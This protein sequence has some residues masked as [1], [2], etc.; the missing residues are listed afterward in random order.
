MS[1]GVIVGR[2][3]MPD[4]KASAIN[5]RPTTLSCIGGDI[6]DA[7]P[8]PTLPR[9]GR[10]RVLRGREYFGSG[11]GGGGGSGFFVLRG[12]AFCSAC[13]GARFGRFD[14]GSFAGVGWELMGG[15]NGC[16]RVVGR[17]FMPDV[18]VVGHK[19]PTYVCCG[20][21]IGGMRAN[22]TPIPSPTGG[23]GQSGGGS[24]SRWRL[25]NGCAPS[26]CGGLGQLARSARKLGWG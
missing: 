20:I 13:G 21:R 3:L 1:E 11:S 7:T 10:W 23:G 22:P 26:P 18:V 19:W 8:T 24:G 4:I 16:N 2:A 25:C 17:A 9:C 5:G 12:K 6:E 14:G 15:R